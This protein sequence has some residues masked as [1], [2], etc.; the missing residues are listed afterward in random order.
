MSLVALMGLTLLMS[1]YLITV[2]ESVQAVYLWFVVIVMWYRFVYLDYKGYKV[3]HRSTTKSLK[4]WCYNQ[5]KAFDMIWIIP[6]MLLLLEYTS[7]S[8]IDMI[9][10]GLSVF[11]LMSSIW[12][13]YFIY[14]PIMLSEFKAYQ[15]LENS[16]LYE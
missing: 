5:S 9:L 13:R 4:Y 14:R 16:R 12:Y 6:L 10:V 11:L 7:V 2:Q 1:Y 3:S 15:N 8:F